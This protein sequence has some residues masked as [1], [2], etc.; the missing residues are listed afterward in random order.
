MRSSSTQSSP[1]SYHQHHVIT[2]SPNNNSTRRTAFVPPTLVLCIALLLFFASWRRATTPGWKIPKL[3]SEEW[4]SPREMALDRSITNHKY[5]TS[6]NNNNNNNIRPLINIEKT[7][8]DNNNNIEQLLTVNDA[9]EIQPSILYMI[10]SPP[11]IATTTTN[12]PA[13]NSNDNKISPNSRAEQLALDREASE[14]VEEELLLERESPALDVKQPQL[15]EEDED[16]EP[17]IDVDLIRK[18]SAAAATAATATTTTLFPSTIA[19]QLKSAMTSSPDSSNSNSKKITSSTKQSS[20]SNSII[21]PPSSST[22]TPLPPPPPPPLTIN[23]NH[24]VIA[25]LGDVLMLGNLIVESKRLGNYSHLWAPAEHLWTQ[26]AHYAF[27]NFEG[28]CGPVNKWGK[29]V[30]NYP[31]RDDSTVYTTGVSKGGFNY[32]ESLARELVQ[33]KIDVLTT[34]NNHAFDRGM[35]GITMT[36]R[37]LEKA[38]AVQ[39]G[40]L[41]TPGDKRRPQAYE[42]W[43]RITKSAGWRVAWVGCTTILCAEC[44][45]S[46]RA[47]QREVEKRILFCDAAPLLVYKL[48]KRPD[49]DIVIVGAHWG[50]QFIDEHAQRTVDLAHQMLD[51]GAAVVFGNHPHVMQS[52]EHYRTRDGRHTY[53]VYSIGSLTSGLGSSP[54][55]WKRRT[56]AVVFTELEK[57]DPNKKYANKKRK[58]T[59]QVASVKYIPICEVRQT[60]EM[61]RTMM[62]TT[63]IPGKKCS[64][65]EDWARFLLG[66]QDYTTPEK[67]PF[68]T[69]R[70][71]VQLL[72]DKSWTDLVLSNSTLLSVDEE[73]LEITR[74][75]AEWVASS[76]SNNNNNNINNND[77]SNSSSDSLLLNSQEYNGTTMDY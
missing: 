70:E 3:S 75:A 39:V 58:K 61:G 16:P 27:A 50:A 47:P 29:L 54:R 30:T 67:L 56:S 28:T 42:G 14:I 59:G 69:N 9:D 41:K 33:S 45:S 31:S 24:L 1:I 35:E 13:R 77:G 5:I 51:A 44:R 53:V 57:Y 60:R 62:A 36:A 23:P 10:T 55:A 12:P 18:A 34:A 2:S 38:G 25:G 72:R 20:K 74:L 63:L 4:I 48:A 8:R 52:A 37:I 26:H 32:H 68:V 71:P 65:E 43:Y 40:S 15:N 6:N 76:N 17:M 46:L 11:T 49:V 21:T 73:E 7:L 66:D 64:K 19:T 22:T